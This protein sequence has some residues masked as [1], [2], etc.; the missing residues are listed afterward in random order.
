METR[1]TT[2]IVDDERSARRNLTRRLA[3]VQYIDLAGEARNGR[4]ALQMISDLAP[5]LVLLDIQ[6]PS[7]DGFDVL[8]AL[9]EDRLPVI[10]FVT[11]FDEFASQELEKHELDCLSKP[12]DGEQLVQ[13]LE[14]A[15]HLVGG[16]GAAGH[17]RA[18][19]NLA[20]GIGG[21]SARS[22]RAIRARGKG[23]GRGVETPKLAIRDGGST[24]WV[25]QN[26]IEWIDAAGD[27]MCV[28]AGGKTHILRITMKKLEQQLDP[29]ILQ[30]IHRSTIVN[31]NCVCEKTPHINGEFFLTLKNGHRVKLSR[32]Y[33]DR[34]RYFK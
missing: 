19:A 21:D 14:K 7:M 25:P 18:L 33:R 2:L 13:V 32:S 9:D 28:H 17:R 12:I 4:E 15:R 29:A 10:I 30:R 11:A 23:S 27:Y 1:L 26:E 5:D 8:R 16:K 24:T 20:A 31:V 22:M 34:L 6:M 3:D